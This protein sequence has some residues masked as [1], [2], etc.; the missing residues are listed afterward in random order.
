MRDKKANGFQTPPAPVFMAGQR[1]AAHCTKTL[2]K[3]GHLVYKQSHF[4]G[5]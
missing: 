3:S 4:D 5:I 2:K 1:M